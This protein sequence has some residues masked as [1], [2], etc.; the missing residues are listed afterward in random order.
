MIKRRLLRHV[1][2][3]E[4]KRM[5]PG[6]FCLGPCEIRDTLLY[7]THTPILDVAQLCRSRLKG[8]VRLEGLQKTPNL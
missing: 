7:H 1:A 5:S 4:C 8:L 6:T 3:Q 2:C